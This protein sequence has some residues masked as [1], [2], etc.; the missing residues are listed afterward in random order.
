MNGDLHFTRLEG[1][2]KIHVAFR[3]ILCSNL[4]TQ[5]QELSGRTLR[6]K[7]GEP[8]WTQAGQLSPP[9]LFVA[10]RNNPPGGGLKPR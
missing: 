5:S 3:H 1:G 6:F 10:V 9:S 7:D 8:R 2:F 4:T